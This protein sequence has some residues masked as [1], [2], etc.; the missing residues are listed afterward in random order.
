[1]G[2]AGRVIGQQD[3]AGMDCKMLAV[4]RLEIERSTERYDELSDRRIM[5]GKSATRHR[6]LERNTCRRRQSRS[7]R[8]VS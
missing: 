6:L 4:A 5:P 1:M 7:A 8:N 3:I 2:A